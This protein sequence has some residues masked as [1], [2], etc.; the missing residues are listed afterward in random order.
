MAGSGI[1]EDPYLV[2]S[3]EDLVYLSN[4]VK[5]GTTYKGQTIKLT[6]NLNFKEENSY[7]NY[8]T[9]E[10][11]DINGNGTEEELKTELTTGTGFQPI[12]NTNNP[13]EGN[14]EGNNKIISNLYINN[15]RTTDTTTNLGLFGNI[16]DSQISNLTITGQINTPI[17]EDCGGIIG[18]ATGT[19]SLINLKNYVN[20]ESQSSSSS[21][22]GIIACLSN[23]GTL[24][25]TN[26]INKG[27]LNN[28]NN[29]G[30]L[31]GS[32][33]GTLI[34]ENSY[35][36]GTITNTKGQ[37]A[38]GLL[39]R[40]LETNN[41]KTTIIN[42]HN[43]GNVIT[44]RDTE[45]T[46]TCGGIVGTIYG[47]VDIENCYNTGEVKNGRT[48]YTKAVTVRLGG[49]VGTMYCNSTTSNKVINSYNTGNI[50]NGRYQGGIIGSNEK[51]NTL[52]I[53]KCYNTGKI[54]SNMPKSAIACGGLTGAL[55]NSTQTYILNSYNTGN[56]ISKTDADL[57]CYAGGIAP[58]LNTNAKGTIIN[59]YNIGD[60]TCSYAFA[61]GILHMVDND[62]NAN[63]I[64]NINNVYSTGTLTSKTTTYGILDIPST[65]TTSKAQN[66]YCD[67]RYK[68][69]NK[70]NVGTTMALAD[71]KKTAFVTTLNN[72]IK[73][74]VLSD[75]NA[76]LKDYKLLTWKQ[77]N[78][79]YPDLDK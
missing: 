27:N 67:T 17:E 58:Y 57:A 55:Q 77:G 11:K 63:T 66:I 35:N 40:E 76:I 52:I 29:V 60:I 38:G 79:G 30:G 48:S 18:M 33:N 5:S 6:T 74:I 37:F 53:D 72:N 51:E 65:A 46:A 12:G 7:V 47:T 16:E 20:I 28:S 45:S 41:K 49:I 4:Q 78:S 8:R 9:K 22:G 42:S 1:P 54:E 24:T 10:Y 13:F 39:G 73:S 70:T 59:C 21:I 44:N 26:C 31:I 61:C 71:M 43:T 34:I 3:I 2:Q 25:I 23:N 15:K 68:A 75:V 56:V 69:T 32:S 36:E 50:A 62:A 14:F 19:S 64:I